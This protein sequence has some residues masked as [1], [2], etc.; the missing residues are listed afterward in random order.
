MSE[1]QFEL[2]ISIRK[3]LLESL[4]EIDDE[5]VLTDWRHLANRGEKLLAIKSYRRE[6]DCTLTFAKKVVDDFVDML[7]GKEIQSD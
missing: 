7:D 5:I 4:K 3:K 1:T 2:L 6:H